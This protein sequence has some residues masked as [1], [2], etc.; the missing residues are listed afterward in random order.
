MSSHPRVLATMSAADPAT[1]HP[2]WVHAL[3]RTG[4]LPAHV[5]LARCRRGS[6]GS[7]GPCCG[8]LLADADTAGLAA[9]H[10][11]GS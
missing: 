2:G 3:R 5:R 4:A 8:D 9:S 1:P 7:Q 11:Q 10:A 6:S